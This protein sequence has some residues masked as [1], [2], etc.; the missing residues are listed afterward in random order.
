M[1]TGSRTRWVSFFSFSAEDTFTAT[2]FLCLHI[3]VK[4]INVI[5]VKKENKNAS[6]NIKNDK[7]VTLF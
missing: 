3:N 1:N 4:I 5:E 7:H 2:A 6:S